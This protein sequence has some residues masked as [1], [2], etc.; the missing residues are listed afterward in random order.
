MEEERK[1]FEDLFC[2]GFHGINFLIA[3]SAVKTPLQQR[4]I[5]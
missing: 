3:V 1:I 5:L 4:D 2:V